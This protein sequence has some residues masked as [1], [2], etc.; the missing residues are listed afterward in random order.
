MKKLKVPEEKDQTVVIAETN[1]EESTS[2]A[3]YLMNVEEMPMKD[4]DETEVIM[5]EWIEQF[6]QNDTLNKENK[7]KAVLFFKQERTLFASDL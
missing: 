5:E 2:L 6:L 7:E 1:L 3:L 4:D